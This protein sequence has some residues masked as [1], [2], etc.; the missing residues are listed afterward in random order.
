[1]LDPVNW[2]LQ[3]HSII[4]VQPPNFV[5]AYY[6]YLDATHPT[7]LQA[8]IHY[9]GTSYPHRIKP[10][11]RARRQYYVLTMKDLNTLV[12]TLG[13]VG[14]IGN[15]FAG[16]GTFARSWFIRK[17]SADC[18]PIASY[19]DD[20]SH[21]LQE[22]MQPGIEHADTTGNNELVPERPEILQ[23]VNDGYVTVVTDL[24]AHDSLTG[25]G[26]LG[27]A[28]ELARAK[29]LELDLPQVASDIED[30]VKHHPWMAAFYT[31]SA[32]GYFAPGIL[33]IP[34]LEALGFGAVGIRAGM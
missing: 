20:R 8:L 14:V 17:Q 22:V 12:L 25:L 30:W 1:M 4:Y 13:L 9:G 27:T 32:L 34:A 10:I 11:S 5:A 16:H 23:A 18:S 3:P 29:A 24:A 28:L 31:A 26:S 21:E 2:T 19:V 15:V 6:P 7:S 33:S